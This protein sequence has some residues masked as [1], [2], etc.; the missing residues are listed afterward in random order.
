[1]MDIGSSSLACSAAE[2]RDREADATEIAI[3][4][5]PTVEKAAR[6]AVCS[7]GWELYSLVSLELP[8]LDCF[9]IGSRALVKLHSLG[10]GGMSVPVRL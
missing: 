7:C 4:V 2:H 1:M 8:F 3:V 5:S 10:D 9:T 6:F